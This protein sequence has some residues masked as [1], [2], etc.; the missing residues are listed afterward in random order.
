MGKTTVIASD[1]LRA[2][3]DSDGAQLLSL[4]LDGREYLWQGDERWWPRRAPALFPIV[5]ALR[6]DRCTTAQGPASMTQH[7]IAR[8]REHDVVATT[9]DSVTFRLADDED[10]RRQWPYAFSLS[11]TY[12][13]R[14]GALVQTFSVTNTGDV[15]MPFQLGGHPAFNV[16]VGESDGRFED[17]VLEF[18]EPWSFETPTITNR[19]IDWSARVPVVKDSDVVSLSHR[20]FDRDALVLQDVPG[21]MVRLRDTV[22]GHGMEVSFP[23]FEYC[24]IWSAAGDAPFVAIEPWTGT[25]TGTDEGDA[26]EEK[27]GVTVLGPGETFERTFSMRPF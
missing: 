15:P 5:G 7:G 17:C 20:L 22:S 3:V 24:G 25:A 26:M 14:D 9:D 11:M 4:C 21:N 16:P 19:L 12:G 10:T 18:A 13:F 1:G 8:T 6:D 2:A 23:G 27:R